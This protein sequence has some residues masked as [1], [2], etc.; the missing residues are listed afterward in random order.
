MPASLPLPE[1]IRPSYL[2]PTYLI[3]PGKHVSHTA[4]VLAFIFVHTFIVKWTVG[5]LRV[6]NRSIL[7][8]PHIKK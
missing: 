6:E 8:P 3:P 1:K 5:S 4:E 7:C 2:L